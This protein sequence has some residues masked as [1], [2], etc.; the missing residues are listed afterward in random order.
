MSAKIPSDGIRTFT[1]RAAGA[2]PSFKTQKKATINRQTGKPFL[3]TKK[4]HK[5]FMTNV[6]SGFLCQ[7]RSAIPIED[8]ETLTERQVRSLIASLL[9]LDD[10][11]TNIPQLHVNVTLCAKGDE[12][13]DIL[14]E[15]L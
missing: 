5:A 7:L 3:Y 2:V 11:W 10:C 9:P 4:E 15:P 13:A 12:G 1:L 6:T 8:V 14:I